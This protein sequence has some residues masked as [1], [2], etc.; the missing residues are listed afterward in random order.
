MKI[1]VT[2]FEPFD[3]SPINPS[4][5]V[6]RALNQHPP[7][8][9]NLHTAI[10]PVDY[11]R[12]PQVLLQAVEACQPEAVVCLGENRGSA[13]LRIERVGINLLDFRIPDNQGIQ[14]IDEPILAGEAAAYFATLPVRKLLQGVQEAGIPAELSL[15]AGAYLCNQVLYTLLAHLQ[16][17]PRLIPAGFIHL[18]SLPEQAALEKRNIPSMSLETMLRGMQIILSLLEDSQPSG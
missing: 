13:A 4:E 7:A 14:M 2:G 8:G 3:E 11:Q 10:L 18:P 16:R 9:T 17:Q 6:V 1:L 5:Q 12:G 15:S